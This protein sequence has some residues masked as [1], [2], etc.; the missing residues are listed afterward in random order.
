MEDR[1]A[2]LSRL[3]VVRVYH[4]H[5]FAFFHGNDINV[6]YSKEG[7]VEI[8]ESFY[9]F[10]GKPVEAACVQRKPL[11][12]TQRGTEKCCIQVLC[13]TGVKDTEIAFALQTAVVL[14][15][16]GLH[17]HPLLQIGEMVLQHIGIRD[18]VRYKVQAVVLLKEGVYLCGTQRR[19]TVTDFS[20]SKIGIRRHTVAH[21]PKACHAVE[22][23]P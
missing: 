7:N 21:M 6:I 10:E 23:F 17:N 15:G 1:R 12:F 4:L 9:E 13:H 14:D 2:A 22:L 3:D 16:E 20:R 5:R 11:Y 18:F 8:A 19:I